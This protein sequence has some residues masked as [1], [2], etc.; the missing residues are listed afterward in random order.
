MKPAPK[1]NA[2]KK[3]NVRLREHALQLMTVMMK[4]PQK[5]SRHIQLKAH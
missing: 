5:K 4:Q 3:P 2:L 1:E